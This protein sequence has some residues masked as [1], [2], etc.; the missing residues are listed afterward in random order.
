L[1]LRSL[2]LPLPVLVWALGSAPP[3]LG[4]DSGPRPGRARVAD[5]QIERDGDR[6]QV[7]Y[8]LDNA[9]T[10][11]L[12]EKLQAGIPIRF[13]HRV[14]VTTR[15][16]MPLWP[17]RSVASA[18]V[19]TSAKY[20]SLT[21]R[22]ELTRITET[23]SKGKGKSAPVKHE[24]STVLRP[25]AE[26]WMTDLSALPALDLSALPDGTTA[27]VRVESALGRKW[28]VLVPTRRTVSEVRKLEP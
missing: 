6:L 22:Y 9:L 13:R 8:R 2:L 28:V 14:E 5:L 26:S 4:A 21:H 24:S 1:I 19:E 10:E 15:H 23:S 27:R 7:S 12:V 20:D 16:W 25:E 3:V 18:T 17:D 11:E